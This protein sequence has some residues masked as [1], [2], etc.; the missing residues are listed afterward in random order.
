MV[1]RRLRQR[2]F[3]RLSPF[4]FLDSPPAPWKLGDETQRRSFLWVEDCVGAVVL[5]LNS[6]FSVNIGSSQ[7]VNIDEFAL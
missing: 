7:S 3:E 4:V 2:C 6:P 1:V 5:L